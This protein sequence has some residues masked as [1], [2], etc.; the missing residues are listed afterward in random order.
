MV[1]IWV[2]S[3]AT[4]IGIKRGRPVCKKKKLSGG[5]R[6]LSKQKVNQTL[7]ESEP[8]SQTKKK[9]QWNQSS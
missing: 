7:N 1:K 8:N 3:L 4:A 5:G 6:L 2:P 9:T